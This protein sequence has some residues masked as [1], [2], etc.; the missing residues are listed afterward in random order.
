MQSRQPA[1]WVQGWSL[2]A[3]TSLGWGHGHRWVYEA[4][5]TIVLPGNTKATSRVS[6]KVKLFPADRSQRLPDRAEALVVGAMTWWRHC[7]SFLS[8]G[9]LSSGLGVQGPFTSGGAGSN[10]SS[11]QPSQQGGR[12]SAGEG[13]V[14][15]VQFISTAIYSLPIVRSRSGSAFSFEQMM[16][17]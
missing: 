4:A 10:S 15:S 6:V 11:A 2:F 3:V 1:S 7:G 17:K 16:A 13:S 12:L 14:G 9:A 8:A 5:N